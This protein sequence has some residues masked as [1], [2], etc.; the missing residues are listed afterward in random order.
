MLRVAR[1]AGPLGTA[2]AIADAEAPDEI[3]EVAAHTVD[4]P[5]AWAEALE[6]LVEGLR[7]RGPD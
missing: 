4:G 1:E 7:R 6:L 5:W 3:L 2:V